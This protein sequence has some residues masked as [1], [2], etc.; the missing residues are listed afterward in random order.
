[1]S[2]QRDGNRI[3]ISAEIAEDEYALFLFSLGMFAA[4]AFKDNAEIGWFFISLV[5]RLL[6]GAPNFKQ[7]EVPADRSQSFTPQHIAVS[8]LPPEAAN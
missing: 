8:E 2:F 4:A 6:Q 3:T 7:Y 5:N 1:M